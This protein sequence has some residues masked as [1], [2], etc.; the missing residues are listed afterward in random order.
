MKNVTPIEAKKI[1]DVSNDNFIILDVR[2]PEEFFE[3]H[4]DNA[5]NLDFYSDEFAAELERLDKSKI[6][7]VYCRTG[8]R[9]AIAGV[10]MKKLGI[11]VINMEGGIMLWSMQGV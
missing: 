2:T 5:I 6:Y 9:S 8:Y 7:L 4:L 1:I 11:D 3:Y 10:N